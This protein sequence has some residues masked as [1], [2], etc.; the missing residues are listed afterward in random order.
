ML[1]GILSHTLTTRQ[2]EAGLELQEDDHV[3]QI[4]RKGGVLA[5][6]LITRENPTIEELQEEA[7]RILETEAHYWGKAIQFVLTCPK[8]GQEH[9]RATWGYPTRERCGCGFE[10]QS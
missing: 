2:R 3:V 6:F 5:T 9:H 4:T 1:T 8:C 7:D 10:F